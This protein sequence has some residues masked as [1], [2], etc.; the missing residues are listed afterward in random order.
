MRLLGL[1]APKIGEL[2]TLNV[3]RACGARHRVMVRPI[4]D[5]LRVNV[6]ENGPHAGLDMNGEEESDSMGLASD[7]QRKPRFFQWKDIF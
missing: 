6:V 1:G 4:A 7:F 2:D 3:R 5:G